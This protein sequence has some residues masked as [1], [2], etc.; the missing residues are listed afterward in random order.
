MRY[1]KKQ[2]VGI[3][4]PVVAVLGLW[5]LMKFGWYERVAATLGDLV[6]KLL[7]AMLNLA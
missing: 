5:S 2:L 4:A 7:T 1:A 3:L 6:S